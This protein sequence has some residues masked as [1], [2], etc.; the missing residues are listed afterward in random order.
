MNLWIKPIDQVTVVGFLDK[1][2]QPGPLDLPYDHPRLKLI[3]VPYFEFTSIFKAISAIPAVVYTSLELILAMAKADHIHLRCPGNVGL[4]GCLVQMLFPWKK[5]TA[6]YAGNWDWASQQPWSYRLQQRIL[7]STLLTH[8]MKALVYGEWPDRN[9]N[10]HPFFTATYWE[11]EATPFRKPPLAD[12][13]NICFVGTITE[14]KRADIPLETCIALNQASY[15]ANL[16]YCG[17][18]SLLP[19]LQA[20]TKRL[21]LAAKVHFHGKIDQ[22]KVKQILQQSHFLVFTS[23]SEGW[24]KAVAEA[25]FWGCV[26]ITTPVS[27]VPQMVG[28]NGERGI[29]VEGQNLQKET[30]EAILNYIN[31][32]NSYLKASQR[33]SEWSRQ[34]TLDKFEQE[35]LKL[36]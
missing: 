20:K 9:K 22:E 19:T 3:P 4:I 14:N 8:S 1:D 18:G 25:M 11:R 29:I 17:D 21:G 15:D 28:A 26:P 33:S 36:L 10:I 12:G 5:K 32:P 13:I 27:C 31:N 2:H 6:K 24:P 35:I 16:S 7:R 34:Y 30:T 23:K